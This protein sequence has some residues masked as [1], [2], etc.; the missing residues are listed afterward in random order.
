MLM[1]VS[2]KFIILRELEILKSLDHSQ[3]ENLASKM[4]IVK[5]KKG[6]A[7]YQADTSINHVYI[8]YKGSIKLGVQ[9]AGEREIIRGIIESSEIFGENIFN[10]RRRTEYAVTLEDCQVFTMPIHEYQQLLISNTG[11]RNAIVEYMMHNVSILRKRIDNYMFFNAQRR[12]VEFI[13]DLTHRTGTQLVNGEYLVHHKM[14]HLAIANCTD[15]SRQTVARV[16]NDLKS[17]SLISYSERRPSKIIVRPS[18]LA[19]S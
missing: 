12:I 1:N 9:V 4:E 7:V 18:L 17:R 6:Q 15:T 13:K 3:I 2:S 5:Y 11:F 8:L 19:V 14:N 16:L 10:S